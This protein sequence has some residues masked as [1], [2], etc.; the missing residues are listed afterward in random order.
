MSRNSDQQQNQQQNQGGQQY[1]NS[2]QRN[3]GGREAAG[4]AQSDRAGDRERSI[5]TE[6][7]QGGR[8]QGGA[9]EQA[10][11]GGTSSTSGSGVARR[12][13]AG[14]LQGG[15][16]GGMANPFA[17]MQR[18]SEDM[19]RLFGQL[20]FGLSPSMRSMLGDGLWGGAP[21][22]AEPALWSPQVELFRRGDSLVVR[23]DLPGVKKDDLHLEV[24]DGVL[25]LSGER[26]D[27][28]EENRDGFYRSERSYGQFYRAIPLPEG[29]DPEQCQATF[30]DG[31]LEVTLAAPKPE[32]RKPKRIQIR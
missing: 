9:G 6:R 11:V 12:Q 26:R 7:E 27:Q 5:T 16:P 10:N 23:A 1:T 15:V 25:T 3:D 19:D 17:L 28:R 21:G 32:E 20:G 29:T 24:D 8:N 4:S 2:T 30:E 14:G 13:Q 18:M 31:V 22:L